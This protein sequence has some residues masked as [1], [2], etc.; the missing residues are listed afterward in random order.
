MSNLILQNNKLKD[1]TNG[2]GSCI[3]TSQYHQ[4]PLVRNLVY[5][6][7][8][9]ELCE[10]LKCWWFLDV[11]ASYQLYA[12][13]AKVIYQWW[14]VYVQNN[15]ATVYCTD[16]DDNVIKTQDIPFTDLPDGRITFKAVWNG[17][18]VVVCLIVED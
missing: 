18:R 12:S 8:I 3:G 10:G 1:L 5:T 2:F 9:Y 14:T 7:G 15:Q 11:V 4:H 13:M 16:G 17:A 6:D